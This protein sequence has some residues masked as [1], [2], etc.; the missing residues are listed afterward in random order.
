MV[1]Y[2]WNVVIADVQFQQEV[3]PP[4]VAYEAYFMDPWDFCLKR[5]QSFDDELVQPC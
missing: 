4:G 5:H 3:N 1:V 2:N